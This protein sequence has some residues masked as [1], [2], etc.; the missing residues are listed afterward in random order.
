MFF[1]Q[2]RDPLDEDFYIE[3]DS[4]IRTKKCF[5]NRHCRSVIIGTHCVGFDMSF[6]I[7]ICLIQHYHPSFLFLLSTSMLNDLLQQFHRALLAWVIRT[8]FTAKSTGENGFLHQ[9]DLVKDCFGGF[10]GLLLL[11]K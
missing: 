8:Q 10:F 9:V 1:V 4:S 11:G 2:C 3:I 7:C 6:N 5:Q